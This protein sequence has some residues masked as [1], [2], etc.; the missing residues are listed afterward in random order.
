MRQR[1]AGMAGEDREARGLITEMAKAVRSASFSFEPSEA[2]VAAYAIGWAIRATRT[3]LAVARLHDAGLGHEAAPLARSLLEHSATIAWL[4]KNRAAALPVIAYERSRHQTNLWESAS[5][6]DWDLSH[7]EKPTRGEKPEGP[8]LGQFQSFE[9]M[10]AALGRSEHYAIY[11]IDSG[12]AHAGYLS[13]EAYFDDASGP[14]WDPP[15][16]PTP[17][18]SAAVMLAMALDSLTDIVRCPEIEIAVQDAGNQLDLTAT[19]G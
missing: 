6:A 8:L 1:A 13:A 5:D 12:V 10:L 2:E 9:Q 19:E 18:R 11:R 16:P 3:A 15:M 7:S 14:S 4:E 17:L